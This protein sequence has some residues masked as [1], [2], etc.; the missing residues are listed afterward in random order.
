MATLTRYSTALA[1]GLLSTALVACGNQ[2]ARAPNPP[3]YEWPDS[4]AYRV[5]YVEELQRAGAA[6][7]RL[8]QTALLRFAVR[9]DRF[10]V[11][12]DSV[13]KVAGVADRAEPAPLS[14]EDTLR[15]LV[16]LGRQGEL[17]DVEPDCDPTVG[18]CAAAFPSALPMELRRVIPRLPV[19][20]APA[21]RTWVDTLAFDDLP[22][23]GAARGFVVRAYRVT[24]DTVVAGGGYW[25]V[26]WQSFLHAWRPAGG[27][28]AAEPVTR[29]YGQVLVDKARLLPVLALW[30]GALPAPAGLRTLGMTGTGYRGR[31]WLSGSVFDS[32]QVTR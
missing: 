25:V 10:L 4:F 6:V 31:A 17:A 27:A 8:E 19:W 3:H 18:A 12:N 14:P 24:G 2:A 13:A 22:R 21:G 7:R 11:W 26:G 32:L 20:W 9:N 15:Y 1:T 23:P 28:L 5:Q 30:Y 16:R 29:E